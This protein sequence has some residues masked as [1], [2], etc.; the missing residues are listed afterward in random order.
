MTEIISAPD[1]ATRISDIPRI[2]A[3]PVLAGGCDVCLERFD[4][5]LVFG[6]KPVSAQPGSSVVCRLVLAN[7]NKVLT[8]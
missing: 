2:T 8:S 5:D 3:A 7:L 4:I 6:N 1:I